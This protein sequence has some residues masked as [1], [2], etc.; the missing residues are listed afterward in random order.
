MA[1]GRSRGDGLRTVDQREHMLREDNLDT[2]IGIHTIAVAASLRYQGAAIIFDLAYR[3]AREKF[4]SAH[5]DAIEFLENYN[6]VKG[7]AG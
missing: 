2:L 7:K 4:G 1:F 6:N 3:G 5:P